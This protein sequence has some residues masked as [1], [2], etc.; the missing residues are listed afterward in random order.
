MDHLKQAGTTDSAR[1][2]LNIVV[3]TTACRLAQVFST[4]PYAI[5]TCSFLGVQLDQSP[6]HVVL[7][8]RESVLVFS[9]G[10]HF[11]YRPTKGVVASLEPSI[12]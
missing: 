12:E 11:N 3:N 5:W 9:N 10:T 1:E 8:H 4:N 7:S 6:P 2:M